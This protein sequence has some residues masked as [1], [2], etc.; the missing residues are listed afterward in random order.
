MHRTTA[1]LLIA[2]FLPATAPAAEAESPE[3]A[4]ARETFQSLFGRDVAK[5]RATPAAEDDVALAK[6]LLA[7]ARDA[8][9]SPAF[10]SLLCDEAY[11]LAA[12]HES[13]KETAT[14][15]MDLLA[16]HVPGRAEEAQARIRSLRGE[17]AEP[18]GEEEP[19]PPAE[20]K[21]PPEQPMSPKDELDALLAQIEEK[22]E[23]GALI[24][25]AALYRDAQTLARRTGDN[26]L[27]AITEAAETLA[28]RIG[29]ERR[30]RDVRA[31]LER[32]PDN[33]SAREG[34]VRLYLV[35]LNDPKRA[36][37]ILEGVE[38][39][40]LKKYVPAAAKPVDAAPELACL[41]LG[42]W[43]AGLAER[44]PDYAKATMFGRAKTYLDRFLSL[45]ETK[46]MAQVRAKVAMEKVEGALRALAPA[47]TTQ[48]PTSEKPAEVAGRIKDGVIQPGQWVNLLP[49]IS[50][51]RD[52]VRGDWGKSG[53]ALTKN[54]PEKESKIML[55]VIPSGNYE[56][57]FSFIRKSGG[58]S[59]GG[60]VDA[61]LPVGDRGV[62]YTLSGWWNTIHG[63]Q[64]IDGKGGDANPTAI[65]NMP[66][67]QGRLYNA[68]VRVERT[69]D[70]VSLRGYLDGRLLTKW[71]GPVSGVSLRPEWTIPDSSRLGLMVNVLEATLPVIRFRVLTGE[72]RLLRP[73]D[74]GGGA[75]ET[76]GA[77]G[78][79]TPKPP[80]LG[81]TQAAA[82]GP[83]VDA[84]ATIDP[85][86]DALAGGWQ[87]DGDDLV[88]HEQAHEAK[89][90]AP[91]H[92]EGS[93]RLEAAFVRTA[94]GDTVGIILPVEDRHVVAAI[95]HGGG[96]GHGLD[97]IRGRNGHSNETAVKPGRIENGR[98]YVV[99]VQMS[100]G[101]GRARIGVWLDG[102]QIIDW[103]GPTKDLTMYP[104]WRL[105]H[106]HRL[107]IGASNS[108]VRWRRLLIQPTGGRVR[109]LRPAK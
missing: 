61:I 17:P 21:E 67:E 23:A 13:G 66:L 32:N 20:S 80:A 58:G 95:S 18:A 37:E 31:M 82:T 36:A 51:D 101:G 42:E 44:A 107:A 98:E 75:G 94:G 25:A 60:S 88:I 3:A 27:P 91:L 69:G 92:V 105:P 72:A 93:Y 9:A 90:V 87:R 100:V 64:E 65:R 10:L 2:F 41:E 6:R 39:S 68:S 16:K 71:S 49:Y 24:E 11:A 28:R 1:V 33:V 84:L 104:G 77:A 96:K 76:A 54:R 108:K 14:R 59:G 46:D 99:G 78:T 19:K 22:K 102:K 97:Q 109:P 103:S 48:K 73:E 43:Y 63:F 15:A 34:L 35:N 62:L 5:A 53:S 52:R 89:A 57:V 30:A 12:P 83:V 56:L 86:R 7:V 29:L 4:E 40:G 106:P 45:H 85:A 38:D 8:T 74:A 50:L 47:A 55:P 70:R 26:R 81:P 79:E